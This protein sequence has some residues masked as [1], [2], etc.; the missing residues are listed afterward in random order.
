MWL[1]ELRRL[2][3]PGGLLLITV[4]GNN[5]AK[6]LDEEGRAVLSSTGLIHRRSKKFHGILPS[7]YNTTWHSRSYIVGNL[8]KLFSE[9]EYVEVE[10]GIQDIV[11][12]KAPV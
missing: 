1:R 8:S 7:W 4:H 2:L 10:D 6:I 11:L 5:A 12:A 9:V 3:R